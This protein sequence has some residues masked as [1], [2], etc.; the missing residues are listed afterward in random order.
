M[1]IHL[2]IHLLQC[3]KQHSYNT[4]FFFH[5]VMSTGNLQNW[6]IL[7]WRGLFFFKSVFLPSVDITRTLILKAQFIWESWYQI[8]AAIKGTLMKHMLIFPSPEMLLKMLAVSVTRLLFKTPKDKY[9]IW[10]NS[11]GVQKHQV[12]LQFSF[13]LGGCFYYFNLTTIWCFEKF[14]KGRKKSEAKKNMQDTS[15]M[16]KL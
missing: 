12:N 8:K 2:F 5:Q 15:T 7:A 4:F 1:Y 3:L 10:P 11:I 9:V 14:T 6:L 13:S 16:I